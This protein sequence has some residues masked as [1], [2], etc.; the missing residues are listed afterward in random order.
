MNSRNFSI[1]K[2]LTLS[3]MIL[4]IMVIVLICFALFIVFFTSMIE[5]SQEQ[6]GLQLENLSMSIVSQLESIVHIGNNITEDTYIMDILNR[7]ENTELS[8]YL[9]EN[10]TEQ[11]ISPLISRLILVNRNLRLLDPINNRFVYQD[12]IIMSPDFVD[13]LTSGSQILLSKP[14]IFPIDIPGEENESDLT[15]VLYQ[16]I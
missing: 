15:V 3:Y 5:T 13:F 1:Q 14:G 10:Y 9:Y 2:R 16:K 7:L 8:E 4:I 12:A 6:I 11:S